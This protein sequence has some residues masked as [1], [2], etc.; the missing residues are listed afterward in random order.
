MSFHICRTKA[1]RCPFYFP[2]S[3]DGSS[4]CSLCSYL[5]CASVLGI[6]ETS[7]TPSVLVLLLLGLTLTLTLGVELHLLFY[8]LADVFWLAVELS[9][10]T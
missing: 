6:F 8:V 4:Q 10:A 9:I 5:S 7:E 3:H 1:G 2:L